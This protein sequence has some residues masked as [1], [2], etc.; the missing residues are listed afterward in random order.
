MALQTGST[1]LKT[2]ETILTFEL[3]PANAEKL[4]WAVKRGELRHLDVVG[5]RLLETTSQSPDQIALPR[6]HSHTRRKRLGHSNPTRESAHSL[7]PDESEW[8]H[9]L[10]GVSQRVPVS[11]HW[12]PDLHR[13]SQEWSRALDPESRNQLGQLLCERYYKPVV[14]YL[15]LWLQKYSAQEED[16]EDLAHEFLTRKLLN[17]D[18]YLRY[19][20]KR[21]S[22]RAL[23]LAS[24]QRFMLDWLR[25]N[26]PYLDGHLGMAVPDLV[27]VSSEQD[28]APDVELT[29]CW[30]VQVLEDTIRAMRARCQ[31]TGQTTHWIVF[32]NRFLRPLFTNEPEPDREELCQRLG[33]KTIS[34][35]DS[36]IG[37]V[38]RRFK[39]ELWSRVRQEVACDEDVE[40]EIDDLI[41][42]LTR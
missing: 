12:K 22:F 7:W 1:Q 17:G 33:L 38:K 19:D 5:I 14:V 29:R 35:I 18:L 3:S 23:L 37:T 8:L 26:P 34:E 2:N 42:I 39:A 28:R 31:Q 9:L 11:V 36:L 30:A 13:S 25:R 20:K 15:R 4:F 41:R 6:H 16:V 24:L 40:A 32:E 10:R 27:A 21:G